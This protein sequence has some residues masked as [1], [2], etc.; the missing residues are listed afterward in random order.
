MPAD[1]LG[2]NRIPR[3]AHQFSIF[4]QTRGSGKVKLDT[5]ISKQCTNRKPMR[6]LLAIND[7]RTCNMVVAPQKTLLQREGSPSILAGQ[8]EMAVGD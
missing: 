7:Q 1:Q 2:R 5:S 6:L 4:D 8:S 3:F